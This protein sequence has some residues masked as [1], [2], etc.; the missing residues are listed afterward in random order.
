[1]KDAGDDAWEDLKAGGE[2]AWAEIKTAF[3]AA[4]SKFK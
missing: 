4:A 2:K 3:H 1:L